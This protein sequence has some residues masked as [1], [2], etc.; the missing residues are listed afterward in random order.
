MNTG[1]RQEDEG[2]MRATLPLGMRKKVETGQ[3]YGWERRGNDC[4]EEEKER[5]NGG[6]DG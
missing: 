1:G 6:E 3:K 5:C 4:E 2:E